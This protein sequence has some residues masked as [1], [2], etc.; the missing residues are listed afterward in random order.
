MVLGAPPLAKNRVAASGR[1]VKLLPY[2]RFAFT[3]SLSRDEAIQRLHDSIGNPWLGVVVGPIHSQVGANAY[4]GMFV[5]TARRDGGDVRRNLNSE[6]GELR[7]FNGLQP[8]TMVRVTAKP[9]GSTAQITIRPPLL[10]LCALMLWTAG[11]LVTTLSLAC[12]IDT[13]GNF[14]PLL[15]ITALMALSPWALLIFTFWEEVE[16]NEALVRALLERD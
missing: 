2:H 7:Q 16:S 10:V 11:W 6:P 15:G 14:L 9:S 13:P 5:G 4:R 3:T 12:T 1:D 8:V